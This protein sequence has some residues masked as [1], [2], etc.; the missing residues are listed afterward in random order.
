MYKKQTNFRKNRGGYS[1]TGMPPLYALSG[2]LMFMLAPALGW[3]MS[4]GLICTIGLIITKVVEEYFTSSQEIVATEK[5][6][7]A[8]KMYVDSGYKPKLRPEYD[9][10]INHIPSRYAAW[11]TARQSKTASRSKVAHRLHA[12]KLLQ[13]L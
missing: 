8:Y 1:G 10:V 5:Y 2:S 4:I 6:E 7:A 11:R 12:H 3:V 9:Y 13:T